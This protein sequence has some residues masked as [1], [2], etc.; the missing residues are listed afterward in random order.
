MANADVVIDVADATMYQGGGTQYLVKANNG[1]LYCIYIDGHADV[2]FKKSSDNGI[3]WSNP[4]T[5]YTGTTVQ[6]SIWYDRWSGLSTDLIHC[7]YTDSAV[8]DTFY[9]SVDTAS[10]DGLGTQT[11]IFAGASAVAGSSALSVTVARSGYIYVLVCID[12]GVESEFALSTDTGATWDL[13]RSSVGSFESSG[14]D[15]WILLPGWAADSNDIMCFFFDSN[16]QE[17]SRKLYDHSG[18]TWSESLISGSILLGNPS[19]GFPNFAAA[20]DIANSRNLLVSWTIGDTANAD[21]RCWHITEAAITEVTNVVL[22]ST[23]DQGLCAIG[24]DTATG[25]WYVF[26]VGKSDGSET[27][28]TAVNIYYKVSTDSGTTWGAET[29]LTNYTKDIRHLICVPRFSGSFSAGYFGS[30]SRNYCA[31]PIT[32]AGGGGLMK[33]PGMTGGMPG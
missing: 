20:V 33:H 13:T 25:K 29:Q 10:S 19:G 32:A 16:V 30:L 15:Q 17:I 12:A 24:I 6:L 7:V 23:D 31:S 2:V 14:G 27:W 9:R 22:N 8:D 1:A 18:D 28:G 11:T 21:L 5:I 4:T 26:Y 3:S